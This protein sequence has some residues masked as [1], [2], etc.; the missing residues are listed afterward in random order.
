MALQ[1]TSRNKMRQ[2]AETINFKL[3]L[4]RQFIANVTPEMYNLM[5]GLS[6][7]FDVEARNKKAWTARERMDDWRVKTKDTAKKE[8][9]LYASVDELFT[10]VFGV[11]WWDREEIE[12]E[13]AQKII[14]KA[15]STHGGENYD[16]IKLE[17]DFRKKHYKWRKKFSKLITRH[18]FIS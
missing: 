18:L 2:L 8:N 11:N 17:F 13:K 16:N 14:D 4:A 1:I 7:G 10:S 12:L 15:I 6:H 9:K 5:F 3:K